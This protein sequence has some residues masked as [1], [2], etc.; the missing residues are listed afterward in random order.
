MKFRQAAA[1]TLV[2]WYFIV[3][4][5][6]GSTHFQNGIALN[7]KAPLS[8]WKIAVTVDSEQACRKIEKKAHD[9][10]EREGEITPP[11]ART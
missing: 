3:P 8:Q 6:G 5:F 7:M 10:S 4:P 9:P 2:A 11:Y 1:L